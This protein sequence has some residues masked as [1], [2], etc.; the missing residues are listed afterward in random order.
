MVVHRQGENMEAPSGFSH[1]FLYPFFLPSVS[2]LSNLPHIVLRHIF[3]DGKIRE[4][5]VPAT[6][7]R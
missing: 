1:P 2:S 5:A 6:Q 7:R 4:A 3:S